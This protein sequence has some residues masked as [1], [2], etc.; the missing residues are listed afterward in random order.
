M[1]H[2]PLKKPAPGDGELT[3]RK[4]EIDASAVGYMYKHYQTFLRRFSNKHP[5]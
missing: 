4:G 3:T 2:P 5:D 1:C